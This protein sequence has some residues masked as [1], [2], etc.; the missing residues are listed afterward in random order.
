[1]TE[2][3]SVPDTEDAS[4]PPATPSAA[5]TKLPP[6]F[7]L[8]FSTRGIALAVDVVVLMQLTFYA[9]DVVGLPA[10]LVGG[11]FLAAKIFDGFT[12][13]VVGFL[14]DRT[15][16]RWGKARPY[17]LFI[18]PAWI[19]TI[20]IFSTPDMEQ[21]WQAAYLFITYTIIFSVCHTFLNGSEG[22]YL[23]RSLRGEVQYAKVLSRQGVF[24]ILV[25]A[26]G[27]ITLPQLMGT[28]GTEPGGWT[29]IAL[30]Y[31]IPMMVIGLVRFF[32]VKE[33][34]QVGEEDGAPVDRVPVKIAVRALFRNKFVFILAGLVLV[35][36]IVYNMNAIVGAYYFTYI[37]G[38]IGLLS[39]V[40]M[41]GIILPL[42]YL[43]FPLAVRTIG[44]VNFL[45]IGLGLAILGYGLVALFPTNLIAVTVGQLFGSLVTIVTMLV[46]F[47][48][49]QTMAYGEWKSGHRIDAVT[50]SVTSFMSKVGSG[51]A[52]G[53]VGLLMG[54]VG[55][56]GALAAQTAEVDSTIVSLYSLVPLGFTAIMLGLSFLYKLDRHTGKIAQD[57][58]AGIHADTSDLKL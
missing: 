39:L 16:S 47:F 36:N 15:K 31:G 10:A 6:A 49:I 22:V 44:A 53:G 55:Y 19:L 43:L 45:R 5:D 4:K 25:S 40:S 12:D 17:E 11:L 3:T 37:L 18:I 35:A 9:T 51:I 50:N 1:V 41:A 24:I 54:A 56:N 2:T 46:G 57:L 14:I 29:K 52:S 33:L 13:L 32:T 23:K 21:G 58:A 7:S 42:L 8:R 28:W 34:P 48:V 26:I 30:V 27:S 38:D 20:A